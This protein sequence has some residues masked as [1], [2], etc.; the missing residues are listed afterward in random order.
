MSP[1]RRTYPS[2]RHNSKIYVEPSLLSMYSI[3]RMMAICRTQLY[4]NI[5]Y[6]LYKF[7][8]CGSVHL[9]NICFILIH[10]DVQYSFFLKSLLAQH[11]SDVTASIVRSTTV[12]YSHRVLKVFGVFIPWDCYWWVVSTTP[13]PLYLRERPGN[14]CTGGWVSNRAGLDVCEKSC[15]HRESI[16]GPS[17]P[18]P[19]AIPTELPGP[20]RNMLPPHRTDCMTITTTLF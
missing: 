10:L 1:L 13:M 17:S 15:P 4:S 5:L 18:W 20:Q 19:V 3:N 14:H 12:V 2:L 6:P 7:N 8:V 16:P 9:G 11:V